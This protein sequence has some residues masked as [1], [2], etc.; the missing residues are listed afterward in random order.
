MLYPPT[1]SSAQAAFTASDA[2][3]GYDIKFTLPSFVTISEIGH[4]QVY[5]VK[6]TNN[7]SIANISRY[8]DGVIYKD[9]PTVEQDSF[10]T[11]S[12]TPSDLNSSGWEPGVIY[13]VQLRFGTNAKFSS[14]SS[15]ATWKQT[16]IDTNAFSEWSSVMV[17]KCIETPEFDIKNKI[18]IRK[19]VTSTT[20]YE[21]SQT[22]L[23][24]GSWQLDSSVN[25]ESLDKYKFDIYRGD[26]VAEENLVESSGWIQDRGD[27]TRTYRFKTVLTNGA[28]Y[29]V[30]YSIRTVNGYE[31]SLGDDGYLFTVQITNLSDLEGMTLVIQDSASDEDSN[32][33]HTPLYCQEN[34]CINLYLSADEL[35]SG[36]FVILRS[37][38]ETNFTIWEDIKYLFFADDELIN[39]LVFQDFTIESGVKYRYGIQKEN[40]ERLRSPILHENPI[41][42]HSIDFEYSYLYRDG[43]QLKLSLNHK[44]SS[45]KHTVLRAK[46]DTLG[47]KYPHLVEN[48]YAYYAE[49]P[50][51]GMISLHMDDDNTFFQQRADGLYFNN[52]LLIPIERFDEQYK[53]RSDDT[54]TD[55][56]YSFSTN[57]TNNNIFIERK[58]REKAEEWLNTLDYKLYRSATEGNIVIGLMNVSMTPK[59]EL[60]RMIYEFSAT[61]YEVMGTTIQDL[62][63][64]G[65]ITIGDQETLSTTSIT[66]SFGQIDNIHNHMANKD[67]YS[68]ILTD[69]NVPV[70]EGYR[71]DMR[72][73]VSFWVDQYPAETLEAERLILE[74]DLADE[75]NKEDPDPDI[76]AELQAQIAKL[77]LLNDELTDTTIAPIATTLLLVNGNQIMVMPQKVYSVEG[78]VT[79][80]ELLSTNYPVVLNYVCE[81]SIVENAA[82]KTESA[83]D[84]SVIW[85]QISG[86]FTT[87]SSVLNV[88]DYD[89]MANMSP[90]FRVFNPNPTESLVITVDGDRIVDD[91]NF[92]VYN[93][94][95]LLAII[96]QEVQR[97]VEHDY[98]TSFYEDD[99]GNLTDGTIYYRFGGLASFDIEGDEGGV[100][101]VNGAPI[102]LTNQPAA[103]PSDYAR[104]FVN[105]DIVIETNTEGANYDQYLRPGC[106]YVS[107][108]GA[109]SLTLGST[110]DRR[111]QYL[112]INYKCST[113]QI[114][115]K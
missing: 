44:I 21:G 24:E 7:K 95:D 49:F 85:G 71:Y 100:I 114:I 39:Q 62:N 69:Q 36:N 54:L 82:A 110:S 64:S 30:N 115:M 18:Q 8:P 66:R 113:S 28:E 86:I 75:Y 73:I 60:G 59:A 57:L 50:I 67:I 2:S 104:R 5:I 81:S 112:V 92:N 11:I 105:D 26:S 23:F 79:S 68:L 51:T 55:D 96:K 53:R 87:T 91:T 98:N 42:T 34:A 35:L 37:S 52:E 102:T 45:F 63:D 94:L 10:Y 32:L 78:G 93:N 4:L 29:F 1:L 65:I 101:Y 89:Y 70:G 88:Y 61:A 106:R 27:G 108:V 14:V 107:D 13:K 80:L 74:K 83:I 90:A 111:P 31:A 16:Q 25:H 43:L 97:Q 58:F 17:I 109:F 38:E 9:M 103:A 48:G 84:V 40:R 22:P 46:Q 6:Q 20:R 3:S 19:N 41:R 33:E 99:D 15:F 77:A 72:K 12:I 56:G 47:D 76:I